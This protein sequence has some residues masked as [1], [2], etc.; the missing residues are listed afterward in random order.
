MKR[1][2]YWQMKQRRY[3]YRQTVEY[4]YLERYHASGVNWQQEVARRMEVSLPATDVAFVARVI[5]QFDEGGR[6]WGGTFR[7]Y[8]ET[9]RWAWI[10][11]GF[12]A[13]QRANCKRQFH[14][15]SVIDR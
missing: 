13:M 4:R 5:A 14:D 3:L 10:A 12:T 8:G 9:L 2:I 11:I 6:C 15:R 7:T 1:H